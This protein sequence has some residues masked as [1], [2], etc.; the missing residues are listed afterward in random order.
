MDSSIEVWKVVDKENGSI[1]F[2]LKEDAQD[3]E[4]LE[5]MF[6]ECTAELGVWTPN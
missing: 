4:E 5:A 2:V 6:G 1:Y 3:M